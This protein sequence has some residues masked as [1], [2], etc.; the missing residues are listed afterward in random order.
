MKVIVRN[1]DF[2]SIQ[3]YDTFT[4]ALVHMNTQFTYKHTMYIHKYNVYTHGL[5]CMH[6]WYVYI[7]LY[8]IHVYNTYD[9]RS[10]ENLDIV[11][12][13]I[14]VTL[15]PTKYRNPKTDKE[16]IVTLISVTICSLIFFIC[17][18]LDLWRRVYSNE[19]T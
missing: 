15:P 4:F 16:L 11:F 13:S 9:H 14:V 12:F 6:V 2:Y 5:L 10:G 8:D 17:T 1:V 7:P 3:T 19:E 18:V